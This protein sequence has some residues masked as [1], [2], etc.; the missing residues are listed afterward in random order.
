MIV[1]L[2]GQIASELS[3]KEQ[4]VANVV[5]L[6]FDEECT[7]PFVA[8]YRKERTGSMDEVHIREVRDR[9]S[10][11]EELEALKK[12]C[13]KTVE[14][15]SSK[16]PELKK[17]LP[18]LKKKFFECKKK[19]ELEDLYLPFKPKRKTRAQVAKQM[20]L[21]PL[22]NEV[23]SKRATI[24]M[25]QIRSM[26]SSYV[27]KDKTDIEEGLRVKDEDA[28]IAGISDIYA[29]NISE[30]AS[31]R[32][33]VRNLS[34]SCGVLVSKKLDSIDLE[35][36]DK[37]ED[38]KKNNLKQKALKYQNYFDFK[39]SISTIAAHR[40]MAIRRG[41][42]EKILRF[43]VEVDTD[44]ILSEIKNE[45]F[46]E[47][48][49]ADFMS[50]A[51]SVIDES[52]KRLLAPSI[53]TELRLEMKKYGEEEA[54]KV[55]SKNLENLLLLP[56][57]PEKIVMGID[58]GIRTGSKLAVV[59]ETGKVLGYEV[60]HPDFNN[61]HS[62]GTQQ[63]E[64]TVADF[65]KKYNVSYIA[66]GNGT[67]SKEINSLVKR[68]QKN[69]NFT[70]VKKVFVNESGASVYSTDQIA[71]E[72][73]PDLDPTIRSAISIA[74]RLQDP[75]AELVKIDPRSIGV[76][77]YQ[78]DVNVNKLKK[79]LE[80]TVESC[81]NKVGVNVNTASYSLLSYISGIGPALAKNIVEYRD[82][83]GKYDSR[84][85][86]MSVPGCG[87]KVFQ[88]AA[89]FLRIPDS[90]NPLD[91][92]SVHPESYDVVEHIAQDLNKSVSSLIG[93]KEL[94][95]VL[96]LERYVTANVGLPTLQDITKELIKP[97]RDPREDGYRMIYS[98]EID[99]LEDLKVG[100]ILDGTVT[101]VT[102]F[103][104]FVDVGVHQDGLV[105]L[106][107]LADGF[108]KDPASVVSV[109]D[110]IKVRVIEVDLIRR[111]L[112]LSRKL[113]PVK[114]QS[115]SQESRSFK[116]KKTADFSR[117]PGARPQTQ[118]RSS[119]RRSDRGPRNSRG[120]KQFTVQDLMMKFN[121]R[122]L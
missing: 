28:A 83:N 55:F 64:Q 66:I 88:Q 65:I 15:L 5:S 37:D 103:G 101:N 33:L 9:Y 102:N 44:K 53:E 119:G 7:I 45:V 63:A 1:N 26:A 106:S 40:I 62:A 46:K 34:R 47:K 58:P 100:M 57:L 22:Y 117:K 6:L 50:W 8:R 16:N 114:Q 81:V 2:I 112:S 39:E 56:P 32:A 17:K 92:S 43:Y 76:G 89:G 96:P 52:Y 85:S 35:N 60:I 18:E 36:L 108:V 72:E 109:G 121:S 30:T 70:D 75:L 107:E 110:V 42:A 19:T 90:A 116:D 78:H 111:R 105:H 54:I 20:G 68:V 13:Y 99:S 97:G 69:N 94:L 27:T 120:E 95:E 4:Y 79:S 24:T 74:R 84:S 38:S 21:E 10:Y 91:N 59:S 31:I 80:E 12:K 71:R 77:Q 25:D 67:G 113:N 11:L 86:L 104:A 118:D 49:S 98:D 23:L 87:P 29:E 115:E 93:Q 82:K 122:N 48:S 61:E 51:S 73:F 14:E 3:L 41:E